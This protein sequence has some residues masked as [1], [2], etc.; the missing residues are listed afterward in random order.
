MIKFDDKFYYEFFR[1]NYSES[2][3]RKITDIQKQNKIK[4]ILSGIDNHIIPNSY[5][6]YMIDINSHLRQGIVERIG[7]PL[8][9]KQ[10]I[11]PLAK[12]IGDRKCLE[13]MA[14]CGSISFALKQEKVNI[15]TT[16]DY[17]WNYSENW[18]A[19][20]NYFIS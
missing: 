19:D 10:W 1:L 7:F 14:G 4:E 16:D 11:K 8:I 3:K 6:E 13:V 2:Y 20:K 15:I 9:S 17:S 18:N 12:W 5:P